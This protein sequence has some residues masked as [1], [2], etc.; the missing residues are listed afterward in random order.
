MDTPR[1]ELLPLLP[2]PLT[3]FDNRLN[4]NM[5]RYRPEKE[6]LYIPHKE[7]YKESYPGT[8]FLDSLK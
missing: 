3:S 5:F 4:N 2:T 6:L 7:L 1:P 8:D